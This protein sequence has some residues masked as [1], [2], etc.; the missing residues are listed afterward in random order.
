[1]TLTGQDEEEGNEEGNEDKV[2]G[3]NGKEL[4]KKDSD[5]VNQIQDFLKKNKIANK[6]SVSGLT[7]PLKEKWMKA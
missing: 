4:S 3:P 5:N 2:I 7:R 1:M 6:W